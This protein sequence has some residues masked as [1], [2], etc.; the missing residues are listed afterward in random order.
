M[1][2]FRRKLNETD[3]K[4]EPP[5]VE[6]LPQA[7]SWLRGAR[8]AFEAGQGFMKTTCQRVGGLTTVF[9]IVPWS[10]NIQE[11]GRMLEVRSSCVREDE[12]RNR[13]A[14]NIDVFW[15][16]ASNSMD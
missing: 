12:H 6:F 15:L 10:I 1:T 16:F 3:V 7:K 13:C 4:D 5:T 2:W 11:G 9:E 8:S 14:Q